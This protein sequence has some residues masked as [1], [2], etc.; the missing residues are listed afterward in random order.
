MSGTQ[1]KIRDQ[2]FNLLFTETLLPI[3]LEF[4]LFYREER[5]KLFKERLFKAERFWF[6]KCA[7]GI[8]KSAPC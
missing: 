6:V 4:E 5:T 1:L 2:N 3:S 7:L 8:H